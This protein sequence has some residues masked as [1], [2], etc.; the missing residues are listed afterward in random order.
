[1][2]RIRVASLAL[3]AAALHGCGT[4]ESSP[5]LPQT[6]ADSQAAHIQAVVA[7][8]GVV[9]SILPIAEHLRRFRAGI[10]ERADTLR[11]GSPSIEALVNRWAAAVSARDTA[12]LNAMVLDR[13]EFAWLY[14]PDSKLGKPPY[15]M[16]PELLWA[17]FLT[18]SDEGAK[19]VLNRFG[20]SPVI[21][22]SVSCP[23]TKTEGPNRLHEGCL[24]R[25]ESAQAGREP[26]RL[27]GTIF[28][29]DGRFKFVGFTNAL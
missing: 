25:L 18:N 4:G 21:V 5:Q 11:N 16:P 23:A 26:L 3:V 28:E 1:M 15:E 10:A 29:R 8:G 24:V 27:F 6:A 14:Y 17:Q 13:A 7:A 19:R 9:D 12:E 20:G 22:G 2:I